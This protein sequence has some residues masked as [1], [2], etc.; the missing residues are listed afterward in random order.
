MHGLMIVVLMAVLM[1]LNYQIAKTIGAGAFIGQ[2]YIDKI[3]IPKST[4][5]I[6]ENAFDMCS[7]LKEFTVDEN[8]KYFSGVD[9]VLFNKEKTK[10]I[11]F[12]E[13]NKIQYIMFLICN[14]Y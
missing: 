9:G 4:E 2:L 1:L 11:K 13:I 5:L 3:N 8:N 6:G 7:G 10:L 12:P 14:Y